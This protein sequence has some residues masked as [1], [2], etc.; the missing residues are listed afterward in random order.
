VYFADLDLCTYASAHTHADNWRVP[1]RAV[2]WLEHPHPFVHGLV[3][4]PVRTRLR[5]LLQGS[6]TAFPYHGFCGL[7][8]CSICH[9]VGVSISVPPLSLSA[10]NLLVPGNGCV[11]AAPGAIEHYFDV[12]SY[13]PP[14]E[15]CEAVLRCP[16]CDAPQYRE[17]LRQVNGGPIPLPHV[18]HLD[19][20]GIRIVPDEEA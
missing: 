7:H 6:L 9:P 17:A 12:H 5:A 18:V 10:H 20:N 3:P 16:D 1:L 2:K 14:D 19:D 15:F 8:H 11:Y 4:V 13:C